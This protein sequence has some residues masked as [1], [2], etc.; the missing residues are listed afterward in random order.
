MAAMLGVL[1]TVSGRLV[2]SRASDI[3]F[4]DAPKVTLY[5]GWPAGTT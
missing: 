1:S 3:V 2:A 5:T 4:W